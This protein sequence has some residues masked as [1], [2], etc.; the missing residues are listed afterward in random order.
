MSEEGGG[1]GGRGLSA[2]GVGTSSGGVEVDDR[3]TRP[4]GL[5]RHVDLD[6]RRLRQLILKGKLCPCYPRERGEADV[7]GNCD[8]GV[9]G[10]HAVLPCAE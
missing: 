2:M 4:Q 3:F 5:Y 9:P 1:R 7:Q 6:Y 8:G 10:V